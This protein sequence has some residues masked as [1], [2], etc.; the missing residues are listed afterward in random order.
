MI[1]HSL[2]RDMKFEKNAYQVKHLY[3]AMIRF[4]VFCNKTLLDLEVQT[5]LLLIMPLL[6]F[7]L[8]SKYYFLEV[9]ISLLLLF[10]TTISFGYLKLPISHQLFEI[11]PVNS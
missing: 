11:E 10:N 6:Y 2:K 3:G 4:C 9:D 8:Q 5:I 1:K 7:N